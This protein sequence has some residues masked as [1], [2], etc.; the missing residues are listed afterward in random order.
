MSLIART[1]RGGI[2]LE[3]ELE[4][5]RLLPGRLVAGVARLMPK[6]NV[7]HRGAFATLIGTE[8]WQWERQNRDANGT[9]QTETVTSRDELPRVP[10]QLAEPG[11]F[12]ALQPVVLP[13]ELP[14]PGLGPAT[15]EATVAGVA[16][17]LEV[18]VDVPGGFDAGLVVPVTIAQP[19]ALLRAGVVRVE[20]FALYP[21]ADSRSGDATA[22]VELEPVPWSLGEPARAR[23]TIMASRA[24]LQEVRAELRT[25]VKATVSS[26]KSEEITIATW[27]LVGPGPF[28]GEETVLEVVLDTPDRL[29]PTIDLPHGTADGELHVILARAFAFDTHLVRE[30]ALC[31]TSEL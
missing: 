21:A 4:R 20:P 13:F 30:V 19:M 11:R 8:H 3:F 31:T 9:W 29:L 2:D 5:D 24:D 6:E 22:T 15:L 23:F 17:E 26:G 12:A 16:W 18:K 27:R 7:G 14:V 10:V 28:G 1:S 25:K